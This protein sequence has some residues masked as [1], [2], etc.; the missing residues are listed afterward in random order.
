MI[1]FRPSSTISNAGPSIDG[2]RGLLGSIEFNPLPELAGMMSDK[3]GMTSLGATSGDGMKPFPLE[4]RY[5]RY[6]VRLMSRLRIAVRLQKVSPTIV[7]LRKGVSEY[8]VMEAESPIYKR[9]STIGMEGTLNS[10][11]V[12]AGE[13]SRSD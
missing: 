5:Q 4:M 1:A 3:F 7:R 13:L 9:T 10:L 12:M 2:S 6:G 8:N 11:R